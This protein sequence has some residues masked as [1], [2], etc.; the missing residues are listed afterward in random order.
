MAAKEFTNDRR[1]RSA[2]VSA[3]PSLR[4]SV[5]SKSNALMVAIVGDLDMGTA[6]QLRSTLNQVLLARDE[7]P[8]IVD[9]TGVEFLASVGLRVLVDAT[10]EAGGQ[11]NP[12]RLVVGEQRPVILSL[13]MSG[14]DQALSIYRS[15]D[16]A[17][18]GR[19]VRW[20]P[21]GL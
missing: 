8:V 6:D 7:R 13:R 14:L 4:V 5:E 16:D 1:R 18:H 10:R 19:A 21:V 2:A 9:L 3:D 11:D 20:G 15:V 12:L 17:L